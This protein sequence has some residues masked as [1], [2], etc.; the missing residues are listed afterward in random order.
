MKFSLGPS[1]QTGWGGIILADNQK[2]AV[3]VSVVL[4]D[5]ILKDDVFVDVLKIDIEGADTWA[6]M[7]AERLLRNKKVG[8]IFYEEN[9][10]RMPE[11]GIQSGKAKAFLESHGYQVQQIDGE[12]SSELCEFES[13]TN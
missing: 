8:R 7:G 12:S 6:L 5:D 11:L 2:D 1:E 3:E 10:P 4:L 9:R 13:F